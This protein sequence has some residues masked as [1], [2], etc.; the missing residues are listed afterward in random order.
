MHVSLCRRILENPIS[1]K[2]T[3]DSD[4]RQVII[5]FTNGMNTYILI[6]HEYVE[7]NIISY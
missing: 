3:T 7:N 1:Y 4:I 6:F 2:Q 5:N